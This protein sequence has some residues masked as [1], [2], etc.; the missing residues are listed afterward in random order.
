MPGKTGEVFQPLDRNQGG[1]GLSLA[2][3]YELVPTQGDPVEHFA[4]PLA[5]VSRGDI[6]GHVA[7]TIATIMVAMVGGGKTA[8]GA[9][10]RPC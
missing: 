8:T 5:D 9:P 10:G 2:L 6:F 3:N 4:D 7:P 1:H